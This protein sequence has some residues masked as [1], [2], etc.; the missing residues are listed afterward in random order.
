M[1]VAIARR[2]VT[3][4]EFYALADRG[5]LPE[6]CELID[7]EIVEIVP[8]KRPHSRKLRK[9]R[10]WLIAVFGAERVETEQPI[11]V[12]HSDPQPDIFVAAAA[13][14]FDGDDLPGPADLILVVEIA[15]STRTKD[16][17]RR[18][19]YAFAGVAEYWM[20]DVERG[21][22][23]VHRQPGPDGYAKV[24]RLGADDLLTA[25]GR[26]ERM[27]VGDLFPVQ[28]APAPHSGA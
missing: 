11:A 28:S 13:E 14:G 18:A 22:I 1:A 17:R 25:P 8:P 19:T 2:K 12:A 23:I 7:G 20:L 4:E 16:R 27:R 3:R 24:A 15:D 5:E 10:N 6:R 21:E 26:S 9:L